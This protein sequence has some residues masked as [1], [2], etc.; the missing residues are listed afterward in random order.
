MLQEKLEAATIDN[1]DD[2]QFEDAKSSPEAETRALSPTDHWLILQVT[3]LLV[4]FVELNMRFQSIS[5]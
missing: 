5:V 4:N 2:E 3:F 1:S